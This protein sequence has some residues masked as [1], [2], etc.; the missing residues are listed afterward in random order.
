MSRMSDLAITE[1]E[2]LSLDS[3]IYC[4]VRRGGG[5]LDRDYAPL[6]SAA[7]RDGEVDLSDLSEAGRDLI[8]ADMRRRMFFRAADALAAI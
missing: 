1:Q 5:D 2:I 6:F 4:V 7:V 3:H 8:I